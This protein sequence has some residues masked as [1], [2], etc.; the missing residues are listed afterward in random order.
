MDTSSG[1][2][3]PVELLAE[4]FVARKRRGEKPTIPEYAARYPDLADEIRELFPALLMVE[5]LGD[6]SLPATGPHV[7]SVAGGMAEL[8]QLGDYRILREV[9]RGGM[10]V[11]Y[12]AEQQT[13]GRRVA[14]KV[15][16][17]HALRDANKLR[18]FER[19]ARAA[20]KLHHTNIVPVFG[21]GEW[22]AG[23]VN[24]PI[25]YYVMQF[26]QG[27]GLDEVLAELKQLRRAKGPTVSANGGTSRRSVAP[28]AV[29]VA[30]ALL[31]GQ[32]QVNPEG[33]LV[34]EDHA[35]L[36]KD[37]RDQAKPPSASV[38]S[39]FI[40]HPSSLSSESGRAY[41]QSVARIGQQV[42]EALAYAHSQGVLHRDIKPSN[43]L[44]DLR[45]TVW[46]A[47]F[48]L[49]KAA[50]DGDD[51]THTG[52]IVGTL[53]YMAPERFQGRS[54]GRSDV[55]SLGLTL[56]ELLT[57]QPAFAETDRSKLVQQVT[58]AEPTPPRKLNPAVP[59]DLETIVLKAMAAEPAH[60]YQ[61]AAELAED[62]QR[63][64]EDRP[65]RARRVSLPERF[66][67]W[68]RRNP[69][70]ASLTAALLILLAVVAFGASAAA[71]HFGR[72][73]ETEKGLRIEA[74][75]ARQDSEQAKEAALHSEKKSRQALVDMST[76]YGLV[77]AE[78]NDPG[79]GVLWFAHAARLAGPGTEEE[80]ANRA[81]V[82][83]WSR[84]A[85]QPV[86]AL[87][88]A[89]EKLQRLVF[90]PEGH[91]LLTQSV[92][93]VPGWT[94]TQLPTKEES[95][96]W[97]LVRETPL[98]WPAGIPTASSATWSPDGRLLAVGTPE[99]EVV[100]CTFPAGAE[101]CRIHYGGRIRVLLFS[102]DGHYLAIA[103]A[104]TARVWDCQAG[105][106]ATPE[107]EHPLPVTTLAFHPQ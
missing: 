99:G 87:P 86:R 100:L 89:E 11:V 12:E 49:A 103:S 48:G 2:R 63:F 26:I 74:Q 93:T 10:G 106:Y 42:A 58:H 95:T 20:A 64:V 22:R 15:L 32:F 61:S 4:E 46:V 56:Y 24:P 33:G 29:E 57:L 17:P 30:Q 13:L 77:A 84:Q 27:L 25:H 81:R 62:L 18:R 83:A 90:H 60:R 67:R 19:E 94:S 28:S 36:P 96:L 52:D 80:Q 59:R 21:V 82:T 47:D 55:Y 88:H 53:R 65:I 69:A 31:T 44:L 9:G 104:N 35:A 43:L 75:E 8:K 39:S 68:C 101:T 6:E 73:A 91:Y 34:N 85:L 78:R 92:R 1:E 105:T 97:D 66:G 107:L 38:P 23:E 16:P 98:A 3:S 79:Q 51:L 71:F 102:P 40:L 50:A 41:W 45:G 72:M 37:S 14:L 54:D 76:S 7:G 70:L 5:D